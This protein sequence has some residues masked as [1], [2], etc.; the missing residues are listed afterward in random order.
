MESER[1]GQT[2]DHDPRNGESAAHLHNHAT[3]PHYPDRAK[4]ATPTESEQEIRQVSPP[5]V[6]KLKGGTKSEAAEGRPGCFPAE[7]AH[8]PEGRQFP[9]EE[10]RFPGGEMERGKK[11]GRERTV[12]EKR[13]RTAPETEKRKTGRIIL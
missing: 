3:S 6:E 1:Y 7:E 13:R 11:K 12:Q 10:R 5:G 8:S 9:G 2:L 4:D